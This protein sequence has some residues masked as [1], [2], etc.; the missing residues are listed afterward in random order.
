[1]LSYVTTVVKEVPAPTP[2]IS[3]RGRD[4]LAGHAHRDRRFA[5]GLQHL[6]R[7]L[8]HYVTVERA[9]FT[10]HPVMNLVVFALANRVLFGQSKTEAHT[11]PVIMRPVRSAG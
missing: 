11:V 9:V 7:F 8:L 3:A 6:R 4:L 5:F 1:M 2:S 10:I